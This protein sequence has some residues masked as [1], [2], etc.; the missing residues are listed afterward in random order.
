MSAAYLSPESAQRQEIDKTSDVYS[1]GTILYEMLTGQLPFKASSRAALIV[2]QLLERP[3]SLRDLR[4]E[5][6]VE[7]Q[8]VVLR[9]IEK[10]RS[11]RQQ[12]V[13]QLRQ[14]LRNAT[15]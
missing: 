7:L 1:V 3:H 12:S 4:P 6:S 8:E 10:E 13:Q 11:A 15:F 2:K 5:I 14:Q 9:A